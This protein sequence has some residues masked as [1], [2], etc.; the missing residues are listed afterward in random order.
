MFEDYLLLTLENIC[1]YL[2][3]IVCMPQQNTLGETMK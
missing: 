3:H 2:F 1:Q